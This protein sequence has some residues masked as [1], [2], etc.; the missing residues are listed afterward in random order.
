MNSNDDLNEKEE[1]NI[2]YYDNSFSKN[3]IFFNISLCYLMLKNYKRAYDN[4]LKI[5]GELHES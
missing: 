2:N 3:E 5:N 4:Y 1:K